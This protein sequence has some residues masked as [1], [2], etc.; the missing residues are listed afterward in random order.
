M[1]LIGVDLG[2]SKISVCV[3]GDGGEL[4]YCHREPTPKGDYEATVALIARLVEGAEQLQGCKCSVGIGTPGSVSASTGAM[5]NCNSTCL[6]DRFLQRDVESALKRPVVLA[7]DA[8]CFA[9]SEAIDGCAAEYSN[10]FGLI[11]GTG[12]G[13]GYVQSGRLLRGRNEIAGEWGHNRFPGAHTKSESRSCYCGKKDC[14]ETWLSGPGLER[15]YQHALGATRTDQ[16]RHRSVEQIVERATAG[17]DLALRVLSDYQLDLANAI[18]TVINILDPDAIVLGGGV[19]QIQNLVGN[20]EHT[21]GDFVFADRVDTVVLS[22][23]FGADS[24]VR[25]AARLCS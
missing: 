12:V 23:K 3:L 9:L 20:L 10:V 17:D 21:L 8:N 16:Q 25:G 1:S 19:G 14:I 6:N 24:G 18:S 11:L 7:N 4:L 15:T 5:R 2:G 22:P 13:A